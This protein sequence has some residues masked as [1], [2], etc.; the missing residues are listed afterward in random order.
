MTTS[1]VRLALG[2]AIGTTF[3]WYDFMVY[4]TLAA[5]VFNHVFFPEALPWMGTLLAFSTYAVGY[6]SRPLGSVIFGWLGDRTQAC[7]HADAGVYG[8]DDGSDCIV[9]R[10]CAAWGDQSGSACST[11]V[12]AGDRIRRRVGRRAPSDGRT[13]FGNGDGHGGD[14]VPAWAWAWNGSVRRGDLGRDA[15]H[16]CRVFSGL[17]MASAVVSEPA[18]SGGRMGG[19][20]FPF[21]AAPVCRTQSAG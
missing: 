16:G 7:S 17:G 2:S 6:V 19:Q 11:A 12:F 8:T 10:L 21:R 20:V 5:L 18:A 15:L 9:A 13:E 1:P 4:N 14:M 3:E